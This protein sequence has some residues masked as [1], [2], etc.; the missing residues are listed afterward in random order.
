MLAHHAF[1]SVD[2]VAWWVLWQTYS[3]TASRPAGRDRLDWAGDS[4]QAA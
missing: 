3:R 1:R 4:R 2:H